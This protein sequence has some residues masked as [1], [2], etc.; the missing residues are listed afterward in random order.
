MWS[1]QGRVAVLPGVGLLAA[2]LDCIGGTAA[3]QRCTLQ[4]SEWATEDFGLLPLS[5][6]YMA[7]PLKVSLAA[8][9]EQ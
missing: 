4:K 1:E 6:K 3:E 7:N 2:Q 8:A 9:V 5:C